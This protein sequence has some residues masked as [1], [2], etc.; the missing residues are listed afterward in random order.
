MLSTKKE[1]DK[2][3]HFT[4]FHVSSV[5]LPAAFTCQQRL[6]ASSVYLP[7]AFTCQQRLPAS[8]VYLPAAFTCMPAFAQPL[9]CFSKAS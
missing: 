8:S 3:V 6:P 1:M 9:R 5:Y 7:A 4:H 2:G